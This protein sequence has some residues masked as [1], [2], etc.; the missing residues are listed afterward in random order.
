MPPPEA[1]YE[2]TKQWREDDRKTFG[3]FFVSFFG[4]FLGSFL[5]HSFVI[6]CPLF[7]PMDVLKIWQW[8]Q[9]RHPGGGG[10]WEGGGG[11][12]NMEPFVLSA[13][14]LWQYFA[15]FE[16]SPCDEPRC[17]PVAFPLVFWVLEPQIHN[18]SFSGPKTASIKAV[19]VDM[20]C[21]DETIRPQTNKV[22]RHISI[23]F[24]RECLKCL[25]PHTGDDC[26]Q[27]CPITTSLKTLTTLNKE[28]RPFF[29]CDNSI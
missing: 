21:R 2:M 10:V 3:Y 14:F 1:L 13:P 22:S 27:V 4:S 16:A 8:R 26:Q 24:G 11:R 15:Q 9:E 6:F 20:V 25:T 5:G 17:G 29:L 19:W 7:V 23:I 28:V 18:L 12:V